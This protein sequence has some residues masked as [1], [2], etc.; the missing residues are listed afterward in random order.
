VEAD[1]PYKYAVD[2]QWRG[3]RPASHA[4]RNVPDAEV[5]RKAEKLG[6]S[7]EG[8]RCGQT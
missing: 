2:T 6:S 7:H 4:Q 3:D 5:N 8:Y 1:L